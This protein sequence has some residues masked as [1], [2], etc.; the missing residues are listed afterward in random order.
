[1]R[2]QVQLNWPQNALHRVWMMSKWVRHF[3]TSF[4][5]INMSTLMQPFNTA[6]CVTRN[7]SNVNA[8]QAARKA[9]AEILV[10]STVMAF[11]N[12]S[13]YNWFQM[14]R[15]LTS[16]WNFPVYFH[17]QKIPCY[18]YSWWFMQERSVRISRVSPN[19]ILK[20]ENQTRNFVVQWYS[21]RTLEHHKMGHM[22]CI[23]SQLQTARHR[24]C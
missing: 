22:Q 23:V 4:S 12:D 24:Q 20:N 16:K 17:E 3:A 1:V 8:I 9:S 5:L 15:V 18:W 13:S 10:Q 6:L 2:I 11:N 21:I 7:K 19:N 14:T